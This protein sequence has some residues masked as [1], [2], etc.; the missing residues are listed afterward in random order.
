MLIYNLLRYAEPL[1]AMLP[2]SY[3]LLTFV[4]IPVFQLNFGEIF[5]DF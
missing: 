5:F 2:A 1:A 3:L 4:F